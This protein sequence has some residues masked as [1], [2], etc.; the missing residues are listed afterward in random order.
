M[1]HVMC[2]HWKRTFYLGAHGSF[3]HVFT[4]MPLNWMVI[5]FSMAFMSSLMHNEVSCL[6]EIVCSFRY[7]SN[8]L[9]NPRSVPLIVSFVILYPLVH[10]LAVA[11]CKM[12]FISFQIFQEL[13]STW[14]PM[15]IWLQMTSVNNPSRSWRT[16]LNTRSIAH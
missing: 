13:Q 4:P 8:V 16:C 9:W 7:L 10:K 6:M 5:P 14:A 12:L 3:D 1:T 2:S 15:S 11:K